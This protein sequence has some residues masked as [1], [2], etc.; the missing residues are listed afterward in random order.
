MPVYTCILIL[1][2]YILPNHWFNE[3]NEW[4]S[5]ILSGVFCCLFVFCFLLCVKYQ[6]DLEWYIWLSGWHYGEYFNHLCGQRRE[7]DPLHTVVLIRQ[8]SVFWLFRYQKERETS[9][10]CPHKEDS[11]SSIYYI[12]TDSHKRHK[13]MNFI[14]LF[15]VISLYISWRFTSKVHLKSKLFK[16]CGYDKSG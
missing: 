15:L 10:M 12:P 6:C 11:L 8:K 1:F 4:S 2:K 9:P 14:K 7:S 3:E 5:T 13:V 16:V